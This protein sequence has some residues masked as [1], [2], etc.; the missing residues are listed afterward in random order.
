MTQPC[1]TATVE[2]ELF[3]ARWIVALAVILGRVF[4]M[5]AFVLIDD[6]N[7]YHMARRT[8]ASG[9]QSPY[10]WP[11]YDVEN[12]AR[13]LVARTHGCTLEEIRF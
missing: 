7:L 4:F 8:W 1:E 6:Q 10:D 12:L 3:P 5:R 9:P 11:S 2:T 13:A